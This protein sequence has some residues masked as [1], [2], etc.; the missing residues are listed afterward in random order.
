MG[1]HKRHVH[2]QMHV[3]FDVG[4]KCTLV[5]TMQVHISKS[6]QGVGVTQGN[7]LCT[8]LHHP[9]SQHHAQG[10]VADT[11]FAMMSHVA[12]F[13]MP[14]TL[15][16]PISPLSPSALNLNRIPAS[17]P[18]LRHSS[19]I[20]MKLSEH[21]H[22]EGVPRRT[23]TKGLLGAFFTVFTGSVLHSQTA[24]AEDEV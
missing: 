2:L 23:A 15:S 19:R 8:S 12:C 17:K 21:A 7:K 13:S 4:S 1:D 6:S 14:P 22:K 11:T 16:T 9:P 20:S 24:V 5:C 10:R 3:T 18:S